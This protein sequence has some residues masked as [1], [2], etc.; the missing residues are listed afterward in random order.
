MALEQHSRFMVFTVKFK[1]AIK[2]YAPLIQ[3]TEPCYEMR[4]GQ[5]AQYHL[6]VS[7]HGATLHPKPR[8]NRVFSS[9]CQNH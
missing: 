1:T 5:N 8:S 3:Q 7:Q 2:D 9:F 4:R 6:E